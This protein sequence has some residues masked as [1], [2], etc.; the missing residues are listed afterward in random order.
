MNMQPQNHTK[1]SREGSALLAMVVLLMVMAGLA[2]ASMKNSSALM[3]ITYQ[4]YRWEQALFSAEAGIE[5][6]AAIVSQTSYFTGVTNEVIT[7]SSSEASFSIRPL[8]I[9]SKTF[10][11]ESTGTYLGKT[12]HLKVD[13]LYFPS[14]SDYGLYMENYRSALFR[15][16]TVTQGRV[17]L[18]DHLKVWAYKDFGTGEI[19]AP[20]FTD[21]VETS[22]S[23]I[24]NYEHRRRGHPDA[25]GKIDQDYVNFQGGF[26]ELNIDPPAIADLVFEDVKTAAASH[27]H[28][29]SSEALPGWYSIPLDAPSGYHGNT[30]SFKGNT[31]VDFYMKRV[32]VGGEYVH[33]GF[34]AFKNE[35]L[36]GDDE[37][38]E[39]PQAGLELVY[40]ANDMESP[41]KLIVAPHENDL[42][43]N[44]D[45]EERWSGY[46]SDDFT[47][48]AE[49]DIHIQSHIR[50]WDDVEIDPTS[51]DKVMFVGGDD[52]WIDT[53]WRDEWDGITIEAALL[54][55]G[56][57]NTEMGWDR[58]GQVGV[59]E[60]RTGGA[61]G[62]MDFFG[63]YVG[64][65]YGYSGRFSSRG[66]ISG[67]QPNRR[68]D[69]RLVTDPPP[70]APVL[71]SLVRY[72]GW[73]EL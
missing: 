17:F 2:L 47:F 61:M 54:A 49:D 33:E 20:T 63:S 39:R 60:W 26:P 55:S 44:L 46:I 40:V 70:F 41:G 38:H 62:T 11:V 6:A 27:S 71:N 25:A 67:F 13:K 57:Y 45:S 30:V 69:Q 72:Q 34:V 48:Y 10:E 32:L 65:R 15:P 51:D 53:Q 36:F 43:I 8:D 50:Y 31:E 68:M 4:Q 42:E 18:G 59:L 52:V 28:S 35:D 3:R 9:E 12:R 37:W 56:K 14:Y 16:G 5:Q 64:E 66:Q 29:Q 23:E 73:H 58:Q 19:Q 1:S 21:Q 22:A 24:F 7:L